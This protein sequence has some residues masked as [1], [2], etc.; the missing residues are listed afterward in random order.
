M[1]DPGSRR[2]RPGPGRASAPRLPT[3]TPAPV[4]TTPSAG[5][6]AYAVPHPDLIAGPKDDPVSGSP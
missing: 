4:A 3:S 5:A 2:H 1:P 6:M